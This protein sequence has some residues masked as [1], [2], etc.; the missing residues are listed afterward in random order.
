MRNWRTTIAG[1]ALIL[2]ASITFIATWVGNKQFPDGTAWG[3]LG[4]AYTTGAGFIAA[5]DKPK[6]PPQ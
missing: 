1:V 6:L 2:G 3:L 4:A 5:A